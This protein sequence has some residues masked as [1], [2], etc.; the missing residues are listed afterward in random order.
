MLN[1]RYSGGVKRKRRGSPNAYDPRAWMEDVLR[2]IPYYQ[3]NQRDLA[4]LL[5]FNWKN[6]NE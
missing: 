2:K 1:S 3:R 6:I 5:P 4:E